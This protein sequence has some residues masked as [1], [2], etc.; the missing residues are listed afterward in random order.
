[1]HLVRP[2]RTD[3]PLDLSQI[4]HA[5]S[6]RPSVDDAVPGL[7]PRAALSVVV[8]ILHDNGVGGGEE[9]TPLYEDAPHFAG[10]LE[11]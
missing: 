11:N 4:R 3:H 2:T 8:V 10:R 5:L 9:A 7:D 6:G 1:M